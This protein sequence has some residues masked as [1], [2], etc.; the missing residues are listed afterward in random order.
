MTTKWIHPEPG[1]KVEADWECRVTRGPFEGWAPIL[2]E[3][4]GYEILEPKVWRKPDRQAQSPIPGRVY[5][6]NKTHGLYVVEAIEWSA[7]T[8]AE[9]VRYRS[10]KDGRVWH[11]DLKTSDPQ[12]QGWMDLNEDG[13]E[14]FTDVTDLVKVVSIYSPKD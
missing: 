8:G 3:D 4:I 6:H 13:T 7:H 12:D 14:R 1:E 10:L 9:S 11:R 2:K 5:E